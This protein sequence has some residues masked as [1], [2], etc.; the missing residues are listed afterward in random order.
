MAK[1]GV[2]LV[3]IEDKPKVTFEGDYIKLSQNTVVEIWKGN[4][5]SKQR[6][7]G[8]VQLAVG[9]FVREISQ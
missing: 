9:Q 3:G 5:T 8:V 2:F 4:E 1:F 7:V 6:L